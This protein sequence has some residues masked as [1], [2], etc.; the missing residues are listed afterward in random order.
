[1]AARIGTTSEVN[2]WMKKL[3][4][5]GCVVSQDSET[6]VAYSAGA[7]VFAALAKGKGGPW[8]IRFVDGG[9]VSWKF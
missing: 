4:D 9:D 5:A 2:A 8:I 3:K 6:A 1:M 7:K